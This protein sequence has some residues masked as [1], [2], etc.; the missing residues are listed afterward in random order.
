MWHLKTLFP[1]EM[2]STESNSSLGPK[3][4][5]PDTLVVNIENGALTFS[6]RR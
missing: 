2:Q 3:Y 1:R 6:E 5:S 4:I